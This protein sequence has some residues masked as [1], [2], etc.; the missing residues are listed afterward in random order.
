[1]DIAAPSRGCTT[2]ISNLPRSGVALIRDPE[3]AGHPSLHASSI[4]RRNHPALSRAWRSPGEDLAGRGEDATSDLALPP[5]TSRR[6][7]KWGRIASQAPWAGALGPVGVGRPLLGTSTLC[8]V[9]RGPASGIG[10]LG[11]CGREGGGG[12][13]RGS[14][15][16]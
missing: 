13:G 4:T 7:E 6:R 5:D 11:V 2:P 15:L 1:M 9:L 3:H 14:P 12:L 8:Q 16:F 10:S